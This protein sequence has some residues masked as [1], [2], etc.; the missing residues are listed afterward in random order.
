MTET[1]TLASYTFDKETGWRTDLP[2]YIEPGT[3]VLCLYR[4]STAK[5]LYHD[6]NNEAD[7]PMQRLRCRAF[8]EQNG[9][10]IVCELQ[11][12]GISGHKVRAENRD[13]VQMIKDYA[14]KQKF[15][16]LLVFMFDRIGRISDETPFVVEWLISHGIRVWASEEGEQRI[17]SHTDRLM[18]CI[19]FWQADSESQK[20]SIRTANSL[21]I[22]NEQ[23]FF[24]GRI[25][26]YGYELVKSGRMNKRKHE[27]YDLAICEDA[28]LLPGQNLQAR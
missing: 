9:W 21:H 15:D 14:L 11:E 16:I 13:K 26:P 12:E 5:Q 7:I 6:A 8:A 28:V 3:R 25:C 23:G 19:R 17:E 1:S 20:T 10:T 27:V 2:L 22:L 18:N 24:T 4:V